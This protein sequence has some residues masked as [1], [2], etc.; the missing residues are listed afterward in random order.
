MTKMTTIPDNYNN[1]RAE[2]VELLKGRPL[3]RRPK[4]QLNHDRHL[5]GDWAAHR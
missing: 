3:C 5:L 4:R 2:I 1:I